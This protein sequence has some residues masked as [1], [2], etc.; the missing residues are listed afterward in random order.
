[1]K[2]VLIVCIAVLD[3]FAG[4]YYAKVEPVQ[5]YS[6]K[7]SASGEIKSLDKAKEGTISGGGRLIWVDDVLD[8]KEL[9]S[10][11]QK[12]SALA[13]TLEMT[14]LNLENAKE[15]EKI[16]SQNYGR[17]KDLKTKSKVEKDNELINLLNAQNQVVTLE[18]SMQNLIIQ[19]SD[20]EFKIASL[21]DK[22]S[23][24]NIHIAKGFFIYKTYVDEGDY[25]NI[26]ASLVD[27]YDVKQGKLTIYL[28]KEDVALAQNTTMYINDEATSY[29]IDKIWDIA[30][31]QNIS[32]YKA[33]ILIPAP[34]RFSELLKIEFK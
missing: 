23:K 28:S 31:T 19:I 13:K 11:Q 26:G 4:V 20:M 18:N 6:I 14:K 24:K 12:L 3:L 33:E 5:M 9:K 7:A 34:K 16:K 22:I 30:D 15:I 29:K 27:A 21:E 32:A 1:M 10:S 25:V 2:Y 8:K 17:I